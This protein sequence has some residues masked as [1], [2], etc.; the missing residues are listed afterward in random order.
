MA[1]LIET[2]LWV[3]FMRRKSPVSLK[4]RIQPWILDPLATLCEP[5][6]FEVL[7]HATPGERPVIEAQFSTLPILSTPPELWKDATKLGQKCREGGFTS[8]SLDL[9]IATVALHHN[10][11]IVTF[12]SDFVSIANHAPLRVRR[13]TR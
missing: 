6:A 11:E 1:R 9:L 12:D 5:V 2:S 8:G 3:D 7:R 4:L 13:L 10:A